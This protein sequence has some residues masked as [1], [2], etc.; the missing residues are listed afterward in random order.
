MKEQSILVSE[1]MVCLELFPLDGVG[2]DPGKS[3]V[4]CLLL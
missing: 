4:S 1:E 3:Q 2:T